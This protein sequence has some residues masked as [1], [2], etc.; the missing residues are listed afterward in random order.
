MKE[1]ILSSATELFLNQGFKSV[2]MDDIA[3]QMGIS[4]K[5]IYSHYS[6]KTALVED[7][8]AHLYNSIC[9]GIDGLQMQANNPIEELY[10]IKLF[11]L[12]HLKGEHTF[13]LQ[14][15]QKYY[16]RIFSELKMKQF[17]YM[18]E[19][20]VKNI[21]LGVQKG[22]YRNNLDI[23]FVA[24]MYFTGMTGIKDAAIFPP[25]DYPP[26]ELHGMY[27]EYHLRGIVTPQGRKILN[28]LIQSNH[29]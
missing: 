5:T 4:K 9:T 7:V 1:E 8:T 20:M 15:L 29:E 23:G 17:D 18:Q 11:I 10:D 2:T 6:Q 24:R 26:A 27:L 3:T 12:K 19:C 14:Q 22:L 25:E 21:K 13:P 16:P 28:T